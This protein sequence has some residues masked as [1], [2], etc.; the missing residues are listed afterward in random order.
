MPSLSLPHGQLFFKAA[1]STDQPDHQQAQM[2]QFLS[3]ISF[4][5][6]LVLNFP[7]AL[8]DSHLSTSSRALEAG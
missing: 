6:L 8:T 1:N 7:G 4:Q 5:K 2:Y 3:A